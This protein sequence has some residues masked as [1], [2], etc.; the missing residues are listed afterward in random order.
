MKN[1]KGF[2]KNLYEVFY[3]AFG[4]YW[5]FAICLITYELTFL[6]SFFIAI[7]IRIINLI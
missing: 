1:I 2:I 5:L 4:E 6:F 7:L 3:D